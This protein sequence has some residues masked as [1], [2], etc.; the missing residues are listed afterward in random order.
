MP[1]DAD[2]NEAW[3]LG[4]R[5]LCV[6]ADPVIPADPPSDDDAAVAS[7]TASVDTQSATVTTDSTPTDPDLYPHPHP[8][9]DP[10]SGLDPVLAFVTGTDTAEATRETAVAATA[11]PVHLCVSSCCGKA[12]T[13][14]CGGCGLVW[15][16]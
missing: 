6:A 7:E 11:K 16:V 9:F 8:D 2:Q 13:Q 10:D 3:E 12:A 14:T 1:P 15:P 5:Q 4:H